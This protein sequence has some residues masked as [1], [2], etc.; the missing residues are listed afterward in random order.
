MHPT[1][2]LLV[3]FDFSLLL[4]W[5]SPLTSCSSSKICA[6]TVDRRRGNRQQPSSAHFGCKLKSMLVVSLCRQCL[7][8][9]GSVF[10]RVDLILRG[11]GGFEARNL[12]NLG[13]KIVHVIVAVH[14]LVVWRDRIRVAGENGCYYS[15]HFIMGDL[16]K[17]FQ[18]YTK[19]ILTRFRWVLTRFILRQNCQKLRQFCKCIPNFLLYYDV[20]F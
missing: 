14:V 12:G 6:T 7:L 1:F 20:V 8:R 3:S 10:N 5:F 11:F 16:P 19:F 15:P 4:E 17:C 9:S 2:L 18:I 13:P